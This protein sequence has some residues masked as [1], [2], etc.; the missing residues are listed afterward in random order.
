M[1][2]SARYS[3]SEEERDT[4]VCF[5]ERQEMRD[6]PRKMQKPVTDLRVKE[7]EAQSESLKALSCNGESDAKNRPYAGA[8]L[9]YLRMRI[10]AS[11]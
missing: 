2:A 6:A 4:V 8:F 11:K 7:Q 1:E 10:A 3:A 5:L 9:M